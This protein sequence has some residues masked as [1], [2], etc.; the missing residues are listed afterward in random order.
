MTWFRMS[1]EWK[2]ERLDGGKL[3]IEAA[4]TIGEDVESFQRPT[5]KS[6]H[7]QEGHVV[8]FYGI[9]RVYMINS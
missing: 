6:K 3:K 9:R 1:L 5:N 4:S 8:Y 7:C 2:A